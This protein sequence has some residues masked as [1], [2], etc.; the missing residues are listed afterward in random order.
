MKNKIFAIALTALFLSLIINASFAF[1]SKNR[2]TI[3]I[4]PAKG[5]SGEKEIFEIH[6]A[7]EVKINPKERKLKTIYEAESTG[8]LI[9]EIDGTEIRKGIAEKEKTGD[10][11][12]EY[13]EKEKTARISVKASVLTKTGVEEINITK[14]NEKVILESDNFNTVI[15]NT[16]EIHNDEVYIE[17]ENSKKKISV[18]PGQAAEINRREVKESLVENI[19][20]DIQDNAKYKITSR[21]SGKLFGFMPIDLKVETEVSA[22]TGEVVRTTNP[23]WSLFIIK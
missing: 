4:E 21:K 2:I 23:W 11:E 6:R 12:N 22:E 8:E 1:E 9:K 14:E 7:K 17:S 20:L 18:M 10:Y 3:G 15:G 16:V 5:Y 19:E 13:N